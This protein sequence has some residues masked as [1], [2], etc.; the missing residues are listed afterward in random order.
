MAIMQ[1]IKPEYCALIA[2]GEKMIELRKSIPKD[3]I[4]PFKVYIYCTSVK[5][6]NLDE[7]VRLHQATGGRID[8]WHGKVI[9]EY[10]CDYIAEYGLRYDVYGYDIPEDEMSATCLTGNELWQYGGGKIL[11]GQRISDLKIY[12]EP[13]YLSEFESKGFPL[14][15]PPQSWYYVKE[16]V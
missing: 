10:I 12:N 2:Q 8:D 13:K 6:M 7:Y 9:D 16:L 15:K 1:S 11:Y 4:P 14:R 5:H 3:L